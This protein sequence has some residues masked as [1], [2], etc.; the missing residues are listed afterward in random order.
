VI[1]RTLSFLLIE[2]ADAF[3]KY[4]LLDRAVIPGNGRI[5]R[6]H[7]SDSSASSRALSPRGGARIGMRV[8]VF[9][10]LRDMERLMDVL[11]VEGGASFTTLVFLRIT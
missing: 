1:L 6:D 10:R 3:T 5:S 4:S 2:L 9:R 7:T 11:D 8:F